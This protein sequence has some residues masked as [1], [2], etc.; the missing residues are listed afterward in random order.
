MKFLNS[1]TDP[2]ATFAYGLA[3]LFLFASYIITGS[4]RAKRILGTLLTVFIAAIAVVYVFPPFDVTEKDPAT[5]REKIVEK[6]KVTLGIDLKGGTTFLIRIQPAE[7][8][9]TGEKRPITQQA[10]DQ[11]VEVLRNRV[12]K[13]GTS[14]PVITPTG[15]DRILVQ[16]PGLATEQLEDVRKQ[17][18]EVAKL[19]FRV[20]NPESSSL[21]PAVE[22]KQ[23]ILDPAWTI[24]PF[25]KDKDPEAAERHLIV[26]RVPDITGEHIKSAFAGYDLEGWY[27]SIQFDKEA[28]EKFF[29]LT[30]AMRVG[31][32]RFA[33]VLDNKILSAPTT[34]VSGGIAGG[35]CRITGKF[36]E[37]EAR[38]LASALLNPLQNPVKIEEERSASASLGQDAISS[39]KLA[40]ILGLGLIT[41]VM[42]I[43]YR[44]SGLFGNIGLMLTIL[45][46]FGSMAMLHAVFTLPGIA[47]VILTLGM[48][49]DAHVLVFERLREEMAAGKSFKV[50]VD[51]AFD[52]AF[53][54]IFDANVTTLISAFILFLLA[55]GPVKGFAVALTIGVIASLFSALVVTRTLYSWAIE[56]FGL[57]RIKMMAIVQ[58]T[59]VNFLGYRKPA[60]ALSLAVIIGSMAYFFHLGDR[61]YGID[62]K[63][64]DLIVME[65]NGTT[66]T[67]GEVRDACEKLGLKDVVVQSEKGATGLDYVSVRSEKETGVKVKAELLKDFPAAK[68]KVSQ[69]ETVGSLVGNEL[70]KS[71]ALA[72]GLGMLGIFLYVTLRFEFSFA[73]GAIVALMHDVIITVGAFALFGR[74]LSLVTVGAILTIGGYSIND[75]IVVFDRIRE[76]VKSGRPGSL[77]QIMNMSVNEMLGRTILTSAST[78]I[79]TIGLFLF[80]GPVLRDFAF[81]ILVGVVTGTYSSIFIAAPV[82]LWWSKRG[83][84]DLRTELKRNKQ[85]VIPA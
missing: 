23:R 60:I 75:T 68:F 64:G 82:V 67:D 29:E 52:R 21:L 61:V 48:A 47:G 73:V 45:I 78:L 66:P 44:V 10:I 1:L 81:A 31:Q 42:L 26:H 3:L 16:I 7:D 11:A 50:A 43:Y 80:G 69:E 8:P 70:K 51:H 12:D 25:K 40:G 4:E 35:G 5:G 37:Q 53:T 74:E 6:G 63:G 28:G 62:F 59:K 30:R 55:T 17:L 18:Q 27:I 72:L 49:V 36:T 65:V 32:D 38:G 15:A 9:A 13:M 14:E 19:D 57:E 2:M 41:L 33:I 34:Q 83:G 77:E 84:H 85:A 56:K 58:G 39:G 46:I 76:T 24:L 20:V 71:S 79:P 54:A 22:A